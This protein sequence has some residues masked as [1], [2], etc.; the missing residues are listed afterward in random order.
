LSS[1]GA[2][3]T[4]RFEVVGKHHGN[5]LVSIRLVPVVAA[6]PVT[7]ASPGTP[8]APVAAKSPTAARSH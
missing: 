1:G 8:A 5:F 4:A 3:N 7:A 6:P 2:E